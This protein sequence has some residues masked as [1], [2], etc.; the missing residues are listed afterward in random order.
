M[1]QMMIKSPLNGSYSTRAKAINALTESQSY[2]KSKYWDDNGTKVTF[3]MFLRVPVANAGTDGL[4]IPTSSRGLILRIKDWD[5]GN[6]DLS[7]QIDVL[8]I[9]FGAQG[10]FGTSLGRA[11][12]GIAIGDWFA[13]MGSIDYSA[14]GVPPTIELWT[15]KKGDS[16]ANSIKDPSPAIAVNGPII[17]DF[18]FITGG[19]V[20]K[21][22][23]S[24]Q[25]DV[26]FEIA[27]VYLDGP[28]TAVDWSDSGERLKYVNEEG[29]PVGLGDDGSDLTGS[30]PKIYAFN[31]DLVNHTGSEIAF[32]ENG[33]IEFADTSPSD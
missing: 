26:D 10:Y 24:P 6:D 23:E 5:D 19:N 25:F 15:Q 4:I 12:H 27:E 13:L 29:K 32:T 14:V 11:T 9:S 33:T 8:G 2:E 31:G 20:L 30:Q 28:D 17:M 21:V 22:G 16:V 18:S 3:A 7:N 1:T